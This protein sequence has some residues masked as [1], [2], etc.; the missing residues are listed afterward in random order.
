MKVV[1][2]QIDDVKKVRSR[3]VTALIA[4][5]D[6]QQ[7]RALTEL[8]EQFGVFIPCELKGVNLGVLEIDVE[9]AEMN[10][11]LVA[12]FCTASPAVLPEAEAVRGEKSLAQ[13]MMIG[14]YFNNRKL[15]EA[16]ERDGHYTQADHMKHLA[17]LRPFTLYP[18]VASTGD[19]VIHHVRTAD[20]SGT[21][22]KPDDWYGIPIHDSQH[23]HLHGHATR[24]DRARHLELA[25]GC[26]ADAMKAE[27][28]R[29]LGRESL[30]GITVEELATFESL[31]GI[32]TPFAKETSDGQS[33]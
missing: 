15:W 16:M 7:H 8:D 21:A 3:H 1:Y 29:L 4:E 32:D 19:V 23:Q 13:R 22:I 5:L 31:I 33:A 11:L 17:T 27:M 30:A 9:Q 6:I 14:G 20:N 10:R 25:V 12:A 28:K 2:L 18:D 24:E 26:T